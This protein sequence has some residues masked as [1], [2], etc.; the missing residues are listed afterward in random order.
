METQ[1]ND[2]FRA[3]KYKSYFTKMYYV[4]VLKY[5]YNVSKYLD[6]YFMY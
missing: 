3:F 1:E 5:S 2:F 4:K 6:S